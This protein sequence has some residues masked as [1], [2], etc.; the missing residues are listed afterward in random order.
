MA[1]S[2][3]VLVPAE[4]LYRLVVE[5]S[6]AWVMTFREDEGVWAVDAWWDFFGGAELRED[7]VAEE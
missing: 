2:R 7:D 3:I 4:S 1:I 5:G 6:A